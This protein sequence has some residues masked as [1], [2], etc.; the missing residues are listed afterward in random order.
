MKEHRPRFGP[1]DLDLLEWVV[2]LNPYLHAA[3]LLAKVGRDK[4]KYPVFSID[5][6]EVCFP[7]TGKLLLGNRTYTFDDF[8]RHAPKDFFPV[9]S[10]SELIER[11]IIS[12]HI[13]ELAHVHE[14][15]V[16]PEGGF[17]EHIPGPSLT[18]AHP[19]SKL[20]D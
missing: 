18:R 20:A 16:V 19:L 9:E 10:E 5:A 13:G 1:E 3:A 12:F 7:R 8:K 6:L 4:L 11:A 2:S 14:L 15:P 17:G